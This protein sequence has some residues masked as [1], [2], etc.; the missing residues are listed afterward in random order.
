[1]CVLIV[2]DELL[3][4]MGLA[5]VLEDAGHE[6]ICAQDGPAALALAARHP[7]RFHAVVTDYHMPGGLTGADV[8]AELRQSYP[9]IPMFI[10]TAVTSLVSDPF[11]QQNRVSLVAKPY[12][13]DILVD[14][15]SREILEQQSR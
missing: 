8:V 7:G 6:V 14:R 3:I 10:V 9:T 13:A 4:R 12:D 1:M 2:E 15:V 11:R 5:I